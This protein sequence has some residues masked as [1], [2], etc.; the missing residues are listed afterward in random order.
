LNESWRLTISAAYW[1]LMRLLCPFTETWHDSIRAEA[2][3]KMR[4]LILIESGDSKTLDGA[5]SL[6]IP[7]LYFHK[8]QSTNLISKA[9]TGS[10]ILTPY[11]YIE[12]S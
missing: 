1:W 11:A 7:V 6:E 2:V 5:S 8:L 12:P 3:V 9:T 4:T 10:I